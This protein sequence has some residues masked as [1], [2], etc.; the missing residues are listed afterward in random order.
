MVEEN[1]GTI[2]VFIIFFLTIRI[3][4]LIK[5]FSI[6]DTLRFYQA[7]RMCGTDFTLIA[8]VFPNRDRDDI[9][10]KFKTEDKANRTL[11]DSALSMIHNYVLYFSS[12]CFYFQE[13]RVPFDLT[14]FYSPS[15]ESSDNENGSDIDNTIQ[16][17]PRKRRMV[18]RK[19]KQKQVRVDVL[20]IVDDRK[21]VGQILIHILA[22]G[23]RRI[24]KIQNVNDGISICKSHDP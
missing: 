22:R 16:K 20:K 18:K 19:Q 10:R 23:K 17:P 2:E 14:C 6:V 15:E 24:L 1:G 5:I 7:L 8:R 3:Q 11:V 13:Q 9:K 12:I 4:V 21:L